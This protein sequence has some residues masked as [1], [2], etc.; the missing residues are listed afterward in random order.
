[1]KKAMTFSIIFLVMILFAANVFA[2]PQRR[3]MR[4]KGFMNR[5]PV[6]MYL[7]LKAKQKELN[8]TD[9]QLEKIKNLEFSLEEKMIQMRHNSSTQRLELRKLLQDRE[10]LDYDE[11]RAAL[12]KAS[13]NRSDIFIER[14]MIRKEIENILTPEQRETLKDMRQ[15]RLIGRRVFQR[16]NRRFFNTQ[17]RFQRFPQLR[18]RIKK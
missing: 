12:S 17:D 13:K 15:D 6:R 16:G 4:D 7:V 2:Q 9:D 10:N 11:M 14:L 18:N 8:I 5:M 1:M 3:M